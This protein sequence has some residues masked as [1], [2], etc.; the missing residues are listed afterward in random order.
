MSPLLAYLD[1]VLLVDV[2]GCIG[3]DAVRPRGVLP[4]RP[5][6]A[7]CNFIILCS[8]DVEIESCWKQTSPHHPPPTPVVLHHSLHLAVEEAVRQADDEALVGGHDH[9][10]G[11]WHD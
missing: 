2:V 8:L 9:Q 11:H 10:Q 1:S 7:H 5:H 4:H 6:L 3:R